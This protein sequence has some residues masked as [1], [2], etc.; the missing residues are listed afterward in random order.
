MPVG[1]LNSLINHLTGTGVLKTPLII[2]AFLNIDRIK[3]VPD[4]A[5]QWAY[6][7]QPLSIAGGQTISQPYTVAFMLELLQPQPG[8]KILDIGAGSG[9]QTSLLAH[10]VSSGEGGG[11]V[12]AVEIVPELCKLGKK[13]VGQFNFVEK[14]IVRWLC[15][16]ASKKE[17]FE[18]A[19]DEI[20]ERV[21]K[22]I[23][24]AA[25]DARIPQTWKDM[26]KIGGKIVVPI[27]NSIWL[28][29]KKDKDDFESVEH[30]GFVFVPFV[31]DEQGA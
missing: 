2:D 16:D 29:I 15:G 10:I 22:I 11:K 20:S 12:L 23:A 24:A 13:N 30:S 26:L 1:D 8:E 17:T 25:L 19:E 31:T 5:K 27:G 14:G 28:F 3:F 21:D 4:A 6:I 18:P 9:W 7:D